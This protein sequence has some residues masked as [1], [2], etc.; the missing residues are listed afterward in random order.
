M[1]TVLA[2]LS[3]IL[4]AR[5][6]DSS[7]VGAVAFGVVT[8]ALVFRR[9]IRL[10][11]ERERVAH[12]FEAG[13]IDVEPVRVDIMEQMEGGTRREFSLGIISAVAVMA[14]GALAA[15]GLVGGRDNVALAGRR[16]R[17]LR[18]LHLTGVDLG[19]ERSQAWS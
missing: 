13:G 14:T 5:N 6:G 2:P 19:C 3:L 8:L 12:Q 1:W 18:A 4:S 15:W 11:A 10:Y 16:V 17:A 9:A 7:G